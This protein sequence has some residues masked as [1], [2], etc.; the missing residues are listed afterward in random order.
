MTR[1]KLND[2]IRD[3]M[4]QDRPAQE[5][6]YNHTYGH[7]LGVALRYTR[8]REEA[9][10]IF[11]LAMLKV[12]KSLNKYASGT[13]YLAW[14]RTIIVTTSIDHFRKSKKHKELLSPVDFSEDERNGQVLND[15]LDK[16]ATEDIIRLIQGLDEKERMIFSMYEID[17]YKHREIEKMTGIKSNTSKWLLAQA[18]KKLRSKASF[19][20]NNNTYTH[21]Q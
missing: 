16:I 20:L 6:L 11:N 12:F 4:K 21:E 19:L 18:K 17:G 1:D 13:N 2:I 14:A 8:D 10:W 3:C 7:L 15:A 5:K 9:E